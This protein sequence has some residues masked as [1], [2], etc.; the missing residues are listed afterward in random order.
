MIT[1]T[2]TSALNP[3]NHVHT[4]GRLQVADANKSLRICDERLRPIRKVLL[5]NTGGVLVHR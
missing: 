1:S 3:Q 2:T 4:R 5:M